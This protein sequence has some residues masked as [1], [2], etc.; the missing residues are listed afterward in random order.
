VKLVAFV[1][2]AIVTEYDTASIGGGLVGG[3]SFFHIKGVWIVR[4]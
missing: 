2:D 1:E 4:R 3:G